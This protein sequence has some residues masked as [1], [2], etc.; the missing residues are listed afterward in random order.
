MS[1]RLP[2]FFILMTLAI[3]AMGIGLMMP[4]MPDLIRSVTGGD[5]AQAAVWGGVLAAAFAVM[6]F[7][8]GPLLGNLSDRYGRRPVL[9][10]SLGF[11]ALDYLVMALAGSIW[12]LLA[13]R[14]VGG[15]T[16]ATPA[17]ATAYIA[18][19]SR[20][21]EKAARFGLIGAAFGLGFVIG[22]LIG[23]LL[24]AMGPR[25]P[26]YAAAIVAA[27]NMALGVLVLPETVKPENRRAFRLSRANPL[28]AFQDMGRLPGLH[29]LLLIELLYEFAFLVYPTTWAYFTQARFGWSVG[30]IGLSLA[31]FGVSIAF[32]Q[33]ALMRQILKRLGERRTV[34]FG[35][36]VNVGAFLFFALVQNGTLAL[37]LTPLTA[38]GAVVTPAL[39][40]LMS[41]QTPDNEQGALQGA[42]ASMR[43][44]AMIL[45]PFAMT[46]IF[47]LFN[48]P[49]APVYLPGAAFVLSAALMLACLVIFAGSRLRTADLT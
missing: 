47:A 32:V 13:G 23:G 42:V 22:P 19:I 45:S 12:L 24:G 29:R 11:M 9:L 7:L 1:N 27:L 6:Q 46:Q 5:L 25:A 34:F 10:L 48:G 14:I 28:G 44:V 16:A 37:F 4:V 49:G 35:L 43:A 20:P 15:I 2:I 40:A 8:F 41:H 33:G 26:L 36:T 30:M 39:Q 3:D 21:E 38:L 18:D 31:S 17:A